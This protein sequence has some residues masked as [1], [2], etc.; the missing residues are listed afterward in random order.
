[1]ANLSS[2]QLQFLS[3]HGIPM[4]RVF[5]AS[6]M[7]AKEWKEAMKALDM[8]VAYGGA[9]CKAAGHQLRSINSDCLQCRPAAIGY[10]K[11][12][13]EDGQVYVAKS[14]SAG[15]F[16]VGTAKDA[17]SR[18]DQLNYYVYGGASDWILQ[19]AYSC[20][21]AG[22]VEFEAHRILASYQYLGTY[23]KEGEEKECRELFKCSYT[24]ARKAVEGAIK[25]H[26]K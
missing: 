17:S 21:T 15:I 2:V 22:K 10:I 25:T 24:Q 26:G 16:K 7:K 23:F 1:V 4:F 18:V 19:D 14:S 9:K 5:D 13:F 11:R 6:G 8:W 12:Y 20:N 3:T